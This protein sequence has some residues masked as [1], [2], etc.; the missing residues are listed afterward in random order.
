MLVS[1]LDVDNVA[2]RF[3]RLERYSAAAVF[4]VVTLDVS[5]A[6]AFDRE[7]QTT[8]TFVTKKKFFYKIKY[9]KLYLNL[10][11]IWWMNQ[12][13]FLLNFFNSSFF[14]IYI[15]F[16]SFKNI[17]KIFYIKSLTL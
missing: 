2:A 17:D 7:A 14:Y 16:K 5:F 9:T 8:V 11:F 6:W 3:G 15:A 4:V 10:N 13:I 12:L 1:K